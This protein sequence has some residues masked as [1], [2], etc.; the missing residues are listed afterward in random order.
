MMLSPVRAIMRRSAAI[1][2]VLAF[3]ACGTTGHSGPDGGG[4]SGVAGNSG[5][6]NGGSGGAAGTSGGAGVVGGGGRGGAAGAVA[7]RGGGG[8]AGGCAPNQVWC[9]GCEPG[10]GA[11]YA[12]GCP[13]ISCPPPDGGNP[14][15]ESCHGGVSCA[16]DA[17]CGLDCMGNI[18]NVSGLQGPGINCSCA[19]GS[20]SCRVIWE[21]TSGAEPPLCPSN[22][23][24]G[25]CSQRCNLCRTSA[26]LDTGYCFCS[27]K[28]SWV[29]S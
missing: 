15:G 10:T 18:G 1:L 29:C 5:G 20:Y 17:A 2:I 28:L 12:G 7:G 27:A 11:C 14:S 22:P 4:G 9:P 16:G 6:G 25:S 21:G 24:G 26:S 19:S 3:G 23:Q 8:G 13:G